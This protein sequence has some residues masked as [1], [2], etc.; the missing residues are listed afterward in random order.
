MTN[1]APSRPAPA[2]TTAPWFAVAFPHSVAW[3]DADRD[4]VIA[5]LPGRPALCLLVAT[6]GTPILLLTGMN[7]RRLTQSRL[8]NPAERRADLNPIARGAHWRIVDSA[9]EARWR[10]YDAARRL[11]TSD[12][13]DL[14][15]FGP[16]HFLH[17]D[18]DAEIPEIRVSNRVYEIAGEFAGPF[19]TA[20]AAQRALEDLWDLFDL[21][22]FPEQVRRAPGGQRCAYF[23]MGRC[24]GPCDGTVPLAPYRQRVAAAWRFASGGAADWVAEAEA[25]M[26]VHATALEFEQAGK[27][28][29]RIAA[30]V[31]WTQRAP[32]R[33]ADQ[34]RALLIIPVARRRAWSIAQFDR[35]ALSF[36]ETANAKQIV[37][38]AERAL[39]RV[40]GPDSEARA[41][42]Q[43]PPTV[44][45]EQTWL[46]ARFVAKAED[47]GVFVEWL[48]ADGR[49][50]PDFAARLR[51]WIESQAPAKRA[52]KENGGADRDSVDAAE[53]TQSGDEAP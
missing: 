41:E 4:A 51:K 1:P 48:D 6:D 11:Q 31:G 7:L 14:I 16:V 18:L 46:F 3:D 33:R 45:K 20:K 29:T 49:Q 27:L 17:V 24:D 47:E 10:H 39:G 34:L 38:A 21:C 42:A 53:D 50:A 19:R 37:A 40:D 12:Y 15:G 28:K 44:R 36:A 32:L 52:G 35:G 43:T 25:A 8:Q 5:A 13:R 26:R 9:F 30:A 22:R 2:P 23:D